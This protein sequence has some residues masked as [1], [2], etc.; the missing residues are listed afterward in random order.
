M[1]LD[2]NVDLLSN[3]DDEIESSIEHLTENLIDYE[4]IDKL[5]FTDSVV[6][7]NRK[8]ILNSVAVKYPNTMSGASSMN[9]NGKG[10]MEST[11]IH[12]MRLYLNNRL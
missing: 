7:Q 3:L 12:F 9:I 6:E 10:I 4:T 2:D 1:K 5:T 8:L 11:S